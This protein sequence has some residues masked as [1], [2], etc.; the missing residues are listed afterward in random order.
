MSG[1]N[2]YDGTG[3]GG[4][5]GPSSGG[6]LDGGFDNNSN[7][8]TG[9]QFGNS[10]GKPSYTRQFIV[11][12]TIKMLNDA[13]VEGGHDGSYFTHGIEL[14]YVRFIGVIREIDSQ[15]QTHTMYKLEDGTGTVS[16]RVWNHDSADSQMDDG[17]GDDNNN[18]DKDGFGGDTDTNGG[19]KQPQFHT[20]DYVE[21]VATV[22][23]FNNKIQIQTQRLSKISDFNN[24]TYHLLNVAKNYLLKKNGG[25]LSGAASNNQDL[26]NDSLFVSEST[27]STNA[28]KSLPDILLDFIKQQSQTMSDGVPMQFMAHEL[29][30]SMDKVEAAISDLV[31]DGRIFST[32]DDTQFLPL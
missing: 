12:V 11:P 27:A 1:F 28:N 13:S 5:G 10:Q 2:P 22:K 25:S 18:M 31:E 23:E 4:Y 21:V 9:S 6:H 24:V 30:L 32:T 19:F 26:K 8:N 29:D 3:Y 15:N 16:I 17:F 14:S 20:N 7:N